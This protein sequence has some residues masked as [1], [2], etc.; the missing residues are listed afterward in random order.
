MGAGRGRPGGVGVVVL[1]EAG[2]DGGGAA[3][4]APQH[5]SAGGLPQ[6]GRADLAAAEAAE[7]AQR[8]TR[9]TAFI[10]GCGVQW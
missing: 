9:M 10:Q 4:A 2:E 8:T 6:T 5:P 1:V 3:R 7:V